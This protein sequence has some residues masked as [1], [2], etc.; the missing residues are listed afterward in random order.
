VLKNYVKRQESV[1]EAIDD[2]L[3]VETEPAV[4]AQSKN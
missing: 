1:L 4:A 2:M 3:R